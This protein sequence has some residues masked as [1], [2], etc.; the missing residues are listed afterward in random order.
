MP[1]GQRRGAPRHRHR[2]LLVDIDGDG[3]AACAGNVDAEAFAILN[4]GNA[5]A[6]IAAPSD[7]ARPKADVAT[8]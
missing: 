6:A 7:E 3:D 8:D 1:T 4:G 2:R 5:L